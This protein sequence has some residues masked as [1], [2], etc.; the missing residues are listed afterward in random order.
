VSEEPIDGLLRRL[1]PRVL[2][3]VVR[4]YG[5]FDTCE[6][7]VQEALLAAARQWRT[8]GVPERPHAWLIQVASR[9]L[10][11]LLRA[12]QA[13][14]RREG[15]VVSWV[16]PQD[17]VAPAADA[18]PASPDDTLVLLMLCCHPSLTQAS[19]IALTLRAVGGLSTAEIARALLASEAS[20]TRRITRAKRTIQ[21]SGVPFR[22]P[23]PAERA[24]RLATVMHVLYLIFTEGYA[25]TAGP[26]LHRPALAAEAIRLTEMLHGLLPEDAEVTGLLALMLLT[27]ARAPGRTT[28]DGDLVPMHEQDRSRWK[29]ASIRRGVELISRALPRGPVGPYQIQAAIAA[30]HDEAASAADTDWSQIVA[31]YKLLRKVAPGP[32]TELNHAVAVAMADGPAVGLALIDALDEPRLA[33]DHRLHAARA[34][35]LEMSGDPDGA[36][37]AYLLAG[38][39]ATNQRHVRYLHTRAERLEGDSR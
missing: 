11:D 19:Q 18:H 6:D 37:A 27:D 12:E 8:A 26:D 35:L 30:V 29:A 25:A 16:L 21:D 33:Q 31:L 39:H 36:R 7:A 23:P 4:R 10:T 32:V 9:R 15:A 20:T 5:H 38:R 22:L 13:R 28:D 34:H 3:A 1:T 14:R 24:E 17:R 2:G